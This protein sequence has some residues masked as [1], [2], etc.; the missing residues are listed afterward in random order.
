MKY[1]FVLRVTRRIKWFNL[2]CDFKNKASNFFVKTI[3]TSTL[4]DHDNDHDHDRSVWCIK[5]YRKQ[6]H[7]AVR[8]TVKIFNWLSLLYSTWCIIH[9]MYTFL[10][11]PDFSLEKCYHYFLTI[12]PNT[13]IHIFHIN[14]TIRVRVELLIEVPELLIEV[15]RSNIV[16]FIKLSF[17]IKKRFYLVFS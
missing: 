15:P 9:S 14:S 13:I 2:L 7:A 3:R 11:H 10:L 8:C 6:L 16:L 4:H 12:F 1:R 17:S 5:K